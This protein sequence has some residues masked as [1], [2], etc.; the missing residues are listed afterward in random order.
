[1][2]S[3]SLAPIDH[4]PIIGACC[5]LHFDMSLNVCL[6]VFPQGCFLASKVPPLS[7][8]HMPV[9]VY[10][11]AHSFVR[12]TAFGPSS[13]L[14]I[15]NMVTSLKGFRCNRSP[16]VI[17]PSSIDTVQFFN[18]LLLRSTLV[19]LDHFFYASVVT[20]DCLFTG[21]DNRFEA[22]RLIFPRFRGVVKA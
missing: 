20:F 18:Q 16:M 6:S 11:P 2:G 9:F 22:K 14:Q 17:C 4:V 15:Q 1:M 3:Q 10:D 19:S 5:S 21:E 7:F 13:Q 12:V 8:L